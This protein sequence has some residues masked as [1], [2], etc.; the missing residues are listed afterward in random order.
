MKVNR[1]DAGHCGISKAFQ[2]KKNNL[3]YLHAYCV[4]FVNN[5]FLLQ[6]S[7]SLI[8]CLL[9]TYRLH[10]FYINRRLALKYGNWPS[11]N[12]FINALHE[13]SRILC[14]FVQLVIYAVRC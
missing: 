4:Y 8:L 5:S 9:E 14:Q 2:L 1:S 11:F 6:L 7:I 13:L 12:L 3:A 10:F